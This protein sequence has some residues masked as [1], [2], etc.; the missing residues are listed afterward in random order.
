MPALRNFVCAP[1]GNFQNSGMPGIDSA[2]M[3]KDSRMA[4][5]PEFHGKAAIV[6][7]GARGLG[8]AIAQMLVERGAAVAIIDLNGQA[9]ADTAAELRR[10]D[11]TVHDVA[12]DIRF[13][14]GAQG[15]VAEAAARL[16]AIDILVNN[17]G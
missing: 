7:G 12:G 3:I 4:A 1:L 11:G 2:T 14:D 15:A 6:T 10:N 9:A 5:L 17:A 16:G 8:R 13:R